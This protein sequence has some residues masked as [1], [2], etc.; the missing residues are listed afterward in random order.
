MAHILHTLKK[1]DR[2]REPVRHPLL[3][4]VHPSESGASKRAPRRYLLGFFLVSSACLLIWWLGPWQ[5]GG[6]AKQR[7]EPASDSQTLQTTRA[8]RPNLSAFFPV[9]QGGKGAQENPNPQ[10]GLDAP[11]ALASGSSPGQPP[12]DWYEPPS[13]QRARAILEDSSGPVTGPTAAEEAGGMPARRAKTRSQARSIALADLSARLPWA[14]FDKQ[15][16]PEAAATGKVSDP[17]KWTGP[18][19]DSGKKPDAAFGNPSDKAADSGE[20]LSFQEV[21]SRIRDSIPIS[22]SML[23]YSKRPDNRWAN[24]NGSKMRE[25]EQ[26]PSGPRVE[27]IT[28]DGIVF[29]YQG[30]R[31]YKATK[32]D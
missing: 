17:P 8:A 12:P 4:I 1:S 27:E 2:A 20:L 16:R 9:P 30:C 6:G 31:F 7:S 15:S 29:N 11:G 14:Y 19:G 22:I 18:A 13:A 3:R 28:P 23:V 25:G 10:M 32:D 5:S 26:M 24:I 21:P